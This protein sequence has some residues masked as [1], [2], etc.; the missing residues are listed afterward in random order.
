[1]TE[2][3]SVL[4]TLSLSD[5]TE[6]RRLQRTI[7][8][9]EESIRR[10]LS[11]VPHGMAIFS[12]D[13]A[14]LLECNGLFLTRIGSSRDD[15]AGKTIRELLPDLGAQWETVVSLIQS[16]GILRELDAK[17]GEEPLSLIVGGMETSSGKCVVVLL[18]DHETQ[19]GEAARVK[20][21]VDTDPLLGIPNRQGFEQILTTETER[22]RRYRGS[23]ALMI[24]DVDRFKPMKQA[25]GPEV[26]EK[27]LKEL[28]S[29]VKSRVRSTDFIGRW[30]EDQFVVLTPMSG[31]L[32]PDGG[33]DPGHDPALPVPA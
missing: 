30:G 32:A 2:L 33:P 28:R 3:D 27:M 29:T 31:Y 17:L 13:K 6:E 24:L 19:K 11:V 21:P 9:G 22:A 8:A 26:A 7:R 10:L 18:Q 4:V 16:E 25:L 15:V 23:L 14:V 12:E 1:M 5:K 20:K